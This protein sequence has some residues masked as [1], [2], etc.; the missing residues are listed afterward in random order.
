MKILSTALLAS[1]FLAKSASGAT[2]AVIDSGVDLM[3][4]DLATKAWV[5]KGEIKRNKADDDNNGYVDDIN[6]WNFAESNNLVIDYQYLGKFSEDCYK[7]FAIQKKVLEGVATDEEKA[8]VKSK[9]ADQEFVKELQKFGNFV[10]GTHVSGIAARDEEAS[11]IMALKIIPTEVK[12]PGQSLIKIFEDTGAG[13]L[14]DIL[15]KFGLSQLAAQQS[16]LFAQIADYVHGGG[17]RVANCSFGTSMTQAKLIVGMALQLVLGREPTEEEVMN[18]SKFFLEEVLKGA[19]QLAEKA[20]NTLFIMAAGN[21][22]TDN[23]SLPVSPA[24][25]KMSNTMTVAATL[26]GQKLASFSNYGKSMVEV[27]APG[28]GIESTIPGNE[29]LV[30]S[31]TS[32]AAPHVALVANTIFSVNPALDVIDVKKIIMETVDMKDYLSGKVSTSGL[33]NAQRAKKAAELS[34]S[35]PLQEAIRQA[36]SAVG[37]RQ[38]HFAFTSADDRDVFVLPMPS[39]IQ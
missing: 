31:G 35:L 23:D 6:G 27:A 38:D 25:I 18:Y 14:S 12:L 33:V 10:H 20:P 9:V 15:I 11:R 26:H 16:K 36:R 24:N 4:P 34:K 1:L 37:D 32:Q 19:K 29:Y 39:T 28:V 5:N 2:L 7:F 21:D 3:H 8:W 22:G 17:A 13:F 30:M